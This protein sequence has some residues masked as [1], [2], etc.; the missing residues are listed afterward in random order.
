M[1][2]FPRRYRDAC[3]TTSKGASVTV[4]LP[5]VGVLSLLFAP[6]ALAQTPTPSPAARAAF[7]AALARPRAKHPPVAQAA[8]NIGRAEALLQESR[9]AMHPTVGAFFNNITYNSSRAFNGQVFQPQIQST[10][11]ASIGYTF[12]QFAQWAAV[13]QA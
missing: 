11:G 9:A 10:G 6:P 7:D 13:A 2:R 4:L 8:T 1:S 12:L 5:K 3:G